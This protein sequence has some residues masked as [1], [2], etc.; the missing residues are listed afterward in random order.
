MLN[1]Q[2]WIEAEFADSFI[3]CRELHDFAEAHRPSRG[4]D[5]TPIIH[6]TL[7]RSDRTFSVV[8]KLCLLGYGQQASML[9]RSLFEDMISA[10][11]AALRPASANRLMGWHE[12]YVRLRRARMYRQH[13]IPYTGAPPPDW[14]PLRKKRMQR[15]FRRNSWTGRS[16][17]QLVKKVEAMWPNEDEKASLWRM[18]DFWHQGLNIVLHHSARSLNY[19]YKV[20]DDGTVTFALGPSKALVPLALGFAFW[21]YSNM[22]SLTVE[23]DDL[24]DLN[25]LCASHFHVMPDAWLRKLIA[26]ASE[27]SSDD[28][29]P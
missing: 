6:W 25:K 29:L 23:G 17:P 13:G 1:D 14:S 28:A 22:V 2:A 24:D 4:R 15:L 16:L 9:N 21:T 27:T 19:G 18:H 26:E 11:F 3:A 20:A 5:D 8:V 7:A 12:E 10:H